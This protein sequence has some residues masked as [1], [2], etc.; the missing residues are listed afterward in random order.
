MWVGAWA[1]GLVRK[2]SVVG[3]GHGGLQPMP[4]VSVSLSGAAVSVQGLPSPQAHAGSGGTGGGLLVPQ[5]S[6]QHG[7]SGGG[8]PTV[9]DLKATQELTARP[10]PQTTTRTFSGR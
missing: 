3:L 7:G 4:S 1:Q 5:R 2:E 9:L 10:G 8:R 6:G